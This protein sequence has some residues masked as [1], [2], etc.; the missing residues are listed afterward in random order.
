M[1]V[2]GTHNSSDCYHKQAAFATSSTCYASGMKFDLQKWRIGRLEAA[3]E[4]LTGGNKT[5]FGRLLGY[6]DGGHVR[7]MVAGTRPITEKTIRHIEQMAGM[8]N[9][10][11]DR[12]Q[13]GAPVSPGQQLPLLTSSAAVT[14]DYTPQGGAAGGVVSTVGEPLEV[15]Q[16]RDIPVV[17][18]AQGG[19][20]GRISIN[21]FPA[22]YGDGWIHIHSPDPA[23][24]ALRVRG[25]SMR[26]RIK[27]GEHIVVEPSIEALPG[28]DVVVKFTDD[29]AVVKELLWIRDDEVC[30]GSINNGVA[31]ITRSLRE[32]M[33]IHR[34]GAIIPR[35]SSMH[36][37]D[38]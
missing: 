35:G 14:F 32:V 13:I 4:K 24:Y 36:R 34:V 21:D 15:R 17:G 7:Q 20:E 38:H 1:K 9:W 28:D 26:P 25:D 8:A 31:P 16:G 30:L 5:A 2:H 23:A 18:E 3:I 11:D 10:F 29:T 12:V 19:P 37:P 22:G 27:S 33:T 6:K